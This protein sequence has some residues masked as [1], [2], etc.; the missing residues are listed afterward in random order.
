M[1]RRG[2]MLHW[3][4]NPTRQPA[5]RLPSWAV[6]TN[7][8]WF[9]SLASHWSSRT[10]PSSV[11]ALLRRRARGRRLSGA[12]GVGLMRGLVLRQVL[13]W[14]R[15]LPGGRC[16]F[17]ALLFGEDLL[18]ARGGL[19][20]IAR[21]IRIAT[22]RPFPCHRRPPDSSPPGALHGPPW[23][24][25]PRHVAQAIGVLCEG[26]PQRGSEPGPGP[27]GPSVGRVPRAAEVTGPKALV[28]A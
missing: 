13:R 10:S 18:R 5:S 22:R 23:E 17:V 4:A 16:L 12:S 2:V 26:L 9:S 20:R 21:R 7:I 15:L 14:A 8:G 28:D 27:W 25:T 6:T 24:I 19:G 3:V 11:A 1:K